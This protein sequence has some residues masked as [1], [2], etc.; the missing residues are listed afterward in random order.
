MSIQDLPIK[1]GEDFIAE[2][3]T[4]DLSE[5]KDKSFLVAVS[6]GDRNKSKFLSTTVHGPYSFV[7]MVEE[8]GVMWQEHQ[9]HAKVVITSKDRSK[10][11]KILDENTIDYIEANYTEI[12]TEAMLDGVFDDDR[13]FTC[14]AG[15][16]E[17]QS[18]EDPR[19]KVKAEAKVE[20]EDDL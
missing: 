1:S 14:R 7:E 15:L 4:M 20:E 9:H 11:L 12:A 18:E 2:C 5:L 16:I 8:V 13:E 10:A 17:D 19:N 6:T 3:E